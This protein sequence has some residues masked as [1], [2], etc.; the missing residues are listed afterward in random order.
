VKWTNLDQ[1]WIFYE[2]LKFQQLFS[3]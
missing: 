3:Y 1:V 2:L